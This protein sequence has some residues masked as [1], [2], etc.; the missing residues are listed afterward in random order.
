MK[1]SQDSMIKNLI[2]DYPEE[3]LE[4]FEPRIIKSLGKPVKVRFKI[5]EIKKHSHYDINLKNDIA[6]EYTFAEN[7]KLVLVLIEHWSDKSKFDIHRLAHYLVDL[8][9]RFPEHEILPIALFT[10]RADKWRDP[11]PETLKVS[12]LGEV[13]LEFRYRLIRMK[14]HEAEKYRES[15][16]R[17][18]AVMRSA[19]RYELEKKI[20]LAVDILKN[21]KYIEHDINNYIRNSDI[22]EY[23]LAINTGEKENIMETLETKEDTEVIIREFIKRGEKQGLEKGIQQ[24]VQRGI[25]I[26]KQNVLI[27]LTR[28]KFGLSKA[29][30]ELIKNT[31][32]TAKLEKALD[33]MVVT[34]VKDE[35]LRELK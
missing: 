23:F 28:K 1:K 21:Y 3:A 14:D 31:R 12:C 5:Q 29:E 17:F 33:L 18:I 8:S 35:V 27:R 25:L 7:R 24:G 19:M 22:I 20:M 26:E 11:P 9:K 6:V 4:F 34:D 15:K 16:N 2:R 10:D 13:F 30:A 32:S